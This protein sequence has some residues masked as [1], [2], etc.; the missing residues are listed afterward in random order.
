MEFSAKERR[1]TKALAKRLM[2]KNLRYCLT[3]ALL[4]VLLSLVVR[5]LQ[6]L[7]TQSL[8]DYLGTQGWDPQT[9][10]QG[11]L[12]EDPLGLGRQLWYFSKA[13]FACGMLTK[14]LGIVLESPLLLAFMAG[15]YRMV[16]YGENPQ[17]RSLF[18]WY[19]RAG[20]SSRA[21]VLSIFLELILELLQLVL[22]LGPM[23]LLLAL[24]LQA[25]AAQQVLTPLALL[26]P[27]ASLG[28]LVLSAFL[29]ARWLPALHFLAKYPHLAPW[30]ALRKSAQELKGHRWQ[31][32]GL[33]LSFLPWL[34]LES[35]TYGIAGI[36]VLPYLELTVT[37]FLEK[38][39]QPQDPPPE[40]ME[41]YV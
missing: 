37:L 2:A 26:L 22:V 33:V 11:R 28:G 5:L 3:A 36:Y 30:G 7:L 19:G 39:R 24:A 13:N 21:I 10:L 16:A 17:P 31:Y 27:L 32:I 38:I 25:L 40:K 15:L 9:V 34:L 4:L 41:K 18:G 12:L 14:L 1:I 23:V 29:Y 35:L 6:G 8:P 20:L